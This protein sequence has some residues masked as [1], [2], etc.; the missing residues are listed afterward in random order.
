M[1]VLQGITSRILSVPGASKCVGTCE[2]WAPRV[3][4]Y[5]RRDGHKAIK[6]FPVNQEGDVPVKQEWQVGGH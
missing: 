1:I 5:A 6:L 3:V 2:Q 4:G